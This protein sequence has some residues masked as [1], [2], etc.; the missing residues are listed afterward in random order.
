MKIGTEKPISATQRGLYGA[1][2][3]YVIALIGCIILCI[4]TDSSLLAAPFQ[5]LVG[6]LYGF[7]MSFANMRV[8]LEKT[9]RAAV[10]GVGI[11]GIGIVLS[12]LT[13]NKNWG[14]WGWLI[15]L[16]RVSWHLGMAWIPGTYYGIRA[17]MDEQSATPKNF[18]ELK[19]EQNPMPRT[20]VTPNI[21]PRKPQLFCTNGIFQGASFP[22]IPEEELLIGSDPSAC[23]I[24][25]PPEIAC[26]IHC[27]LRFNTSRKC[28]QVRDLSNG[29]TFQ[30]GF[31]PLKGS[32]FQDFPGGA[33]LC[34]GRGKTSQR[35]QLG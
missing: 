16:L 1:A 6:I 19:P 31:Q 15:A 20:T 13:D 17:I 33:Q 14:I 30:N 10:Q 23:Q 21:P 3:G 25:L 18:Q 9:K 2:I 28:W 27:S 11:L 24:I 32:N 35:F 4:S 34:I 22:V 5:A 12:K 26:P 29:N 7:G 8:V